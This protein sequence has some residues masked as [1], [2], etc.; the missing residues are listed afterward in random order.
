ME[1]RATGAP[2]TDPGADKMTMEIVGRKNAS[3]K[4]TNGSL[5]VKNTGGRPK[6]NHHADLNRGVATTAQAKKM[7]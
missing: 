1:V 7:R 3:L 6:V 4:S 2:P 5:N